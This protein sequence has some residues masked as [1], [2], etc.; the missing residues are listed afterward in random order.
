MI[1]RRAKLVIRYSVLAV[2]LS[3][4][5]TWSA[6]PSSGK[7]HIYKEVECDNFASEEE[8]L[9][10][11]LVVCYPLSPCM[12]KLLYEEEGEKYVVYPVTTSGMKASIVQI[13]L[14]LLKCSRL[15]ERKSFNKNVAERA[16]R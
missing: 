16:G 6:L 15:V 1:Q 4:P 12:L 5:D 13:L 10:V 11:Q 3:S 14:Y 8:M 7:T 9:E 2:A